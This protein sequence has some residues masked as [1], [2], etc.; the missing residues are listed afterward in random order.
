MAATNYSLEFKWSRLISKF[1]LLVVFSLH[2]F[3]SKVIFLV[4]SDPIPKSAISEIII[5]A[6]SF[7]T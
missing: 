4:S 6:I 3:R 5:L 1:L 7:S 2:V